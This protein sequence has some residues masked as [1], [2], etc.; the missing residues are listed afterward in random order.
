MENTGASASQDIPIG[1]DKA[2]SV[3]RA[4][5]LASELA[6]E[7]RLSMR[8]TK[9]IILKVEVALRCYSDRPLD[10]PLL[11]FM[12]F[13]DECPVIVSQDFLPRSFLTP[14]EGMM[15]PI[16]TGPND[17]SS[18]ANEQTRD[19]QRTNLL[20]EKAPELLG[21]PEDR[22]KIPFGEN[23]KPWARAFYALAPHY[24]PSHRKVLDGVAS[25]L[26]E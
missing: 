26:V 9:R 12:A 1:D 19:A 13:K 14:E 4:A 23:L 7:C 5:E 8:K 11:V 15:H 2:F 22:Y 3:E 16:K 21:L 25:V 10:A 24:I 6:V 18:F 17:L 20:K